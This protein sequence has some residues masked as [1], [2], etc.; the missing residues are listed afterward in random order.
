MLQLILARTDL[1]DNDMMHY[2]KIGK[3][4][5]LKVLQLYLG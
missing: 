4:A 1:T 3:L 2:H 5:N